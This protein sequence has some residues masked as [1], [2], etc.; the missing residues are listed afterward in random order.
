MRLVDVLKKKFH[1]HYWIYVRSDPDMKIIQ[2]YY[3]DPKTGE[4]SSFPEEGYIVQHEVTKVGGIYRCKICGE[5][6]RYCG[7]SPYPSGNSPREWAW[8]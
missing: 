3:Q 1:R 4:I 6:V 8:K 7:L 5:E 2:V